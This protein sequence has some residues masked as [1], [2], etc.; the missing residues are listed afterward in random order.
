MT[1]EFMKFTENDQPS[2]SEKVPL[3]ES[4]RAEFEELEELE[5]LD[6]LDDDEWEREYYS[7]T[8]PSRRGRNMIA[9]HYPYIMCKQFKLLALENDLS[10]QALLG[11][12]IN[13][14]FLKSR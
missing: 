14:L 7:K 8:P 9:G 2:P 3:S 13:D 1:E 6:E 12:A 4:E 11:I 10:V 5:E